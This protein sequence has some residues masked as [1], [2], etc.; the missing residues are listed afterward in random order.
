MAVSGLWCLMVCER[1]SEVR[2][3]WWHAVSDLEG[4]SNSLGHQEYFE[5]DG[6]PR[7]EGR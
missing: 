7:G 5:G 3:T 2:T 1:G 6:K 4:S